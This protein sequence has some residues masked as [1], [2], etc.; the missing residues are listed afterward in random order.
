MKTTKQKK[1]TVKDLKI[2]NLKEVAPGVLHGGTM[3]PAMKAVIDKLKK[4]PTSLDSSGFGTRYDTRFNK[5]KRN[6]K[7]KTRTA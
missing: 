3:D 1:K 7:S 6:K 2:A 5:V 4:D